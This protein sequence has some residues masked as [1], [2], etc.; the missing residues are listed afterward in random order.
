MQSLV[1]FCQLNAALKCDHGYGVSGASRGAFV[2]A[3]ECIGV[4]DGANVQWQV[5]PHLGGL[6]AAHVTQ[7][8]VLIQKRAMEPKLVWFNRFNFL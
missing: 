1:S 5:V 8:D 4:T 6:H 7:K 2:T 3:L